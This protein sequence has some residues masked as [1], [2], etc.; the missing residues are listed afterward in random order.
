MNRLRFEHGRVY[1][2]TFH[3][4][5]IDT[6]RPELA[7]AVGRDVV[8]CFGWRHDDGRYAGQAVFLE[9]PTPGPTREDVLKG[10]WVPRE[11]LRDLRYTE[12]P[13]EMMPPPT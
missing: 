10:Y 7:D 3:P 5:R 6:L 11:D 1:R 8:L 12:R 2:A 9:Y 13:T 4:R